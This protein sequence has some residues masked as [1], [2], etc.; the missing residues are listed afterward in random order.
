MPH[1]WWL[2][3][4]VLGIN[5]VTCNPTTIRPH[6]LRN[7]K[8]AS[9]AP[10]PPIYNTLTDVEKY[11]PSEYTEQIFLP[12]AAK[13]YHPQKTHETLSRQPGQ[14]F[15]VLNFN[16]YTMRPP[17]ATKQPLREH[18]ESQEEESEEN[19][20]ESLPLSSPP[21][22][23]PEPS[24]VTFYGKILPRVQQQRVPVE[25]PRTTVPP[26]KP[27]KAPHAP[28]AKLR[29]SMKNH[30]G[31]LGAAQPNLDY[32]QY[33][34]PA[35][36]YH[37]EL[38]ATKQPKYF[39]D[40]EFFQPTVG[41]AMDVDRARLVKFEDTTEKSQKH[42]SSP[43]LE[44]ERELEKKILYD[45]IF[46][47]PEST[48]KYKRKTQKL[49]PYQQALAKPTDGEFSFIVFTGDDK[50]APR[51]AKLRNGVKASKGLKN[52][53]GKKRERGIITNTT[54]VYYNF[55][56]SH[57]PNKKKERNPEALASDTYETTLPNP[58]VSDATEKYSSKYRTPDWESQR[59]VK[60]I[61]Q[62]KP[63]FLP[64]VLTPLVR[65]ERPSTDEHGDLKGAN[66][67]QKSEK[68][69]NPR[70][71]PHPDD[72][73]QYFQYAGVTRKVALGSMSGI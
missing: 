40:V 42:S 37:E 5:F 56:H 25:T 30:L 34:T 27:L 7:G 33:P 8:Y 69:K 15:D 61:G 68:Q 2:V 36:R 17:P 29:R 70:K 38:R 20:R 48:K 26:R 51:S 54:K 72:V 50:V 62:V 16:A 59:S 35:P 31:N 60:P 32:Y 21:K 24:Y 73:Q 13:N 57:K 4:S 58:E 63:P 43:V 19:S 55:E 64:T 10:L 53:P 49:A 47:H 18:E 65:I 22:D 39:G 66:S 3:I 1:V 45:D 41:R 12:I 23:F 9:S 11:P 67:D 14:E 6:A 46:Y 28:R 71:N 52:F 44:G